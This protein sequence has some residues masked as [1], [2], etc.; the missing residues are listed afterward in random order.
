MQ[1]QPNQQFI[2]QAPTP[3]C[4]N[5]LDLSAPTPPCRV[6]GPCE[7]YLGDAER[8][9]RDL[10]PFTAAQAFHQMFL[11]TGGPPE[12]RW[13]Q[14]PGQGPSYILLHRKAVGRT[15][16][17]EPSLF[18][19]PQLSSFTIWFASGWNRDMFV[20]MEVDVLRL[21][22]AGHYWPY[23]GYCSKLLLP[24]QDTSRTAMKCL[25]FHGLTSSQQPL[26]RRRAMQLRRARAWGGTQ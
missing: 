19:Y 26:P 14:M 15:G 17:V 3:A 9:P 4:R 11:S 22:P 7:K 10:I 6:A 25:S 8:V 18:L 12:D 16:L 24:V 21:C 23:C 5:F 1:L 13:L 2:N 20:M